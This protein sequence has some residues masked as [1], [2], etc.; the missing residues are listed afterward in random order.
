MKHF[1][2]VLTLV[3]I[4]NLGVFTGG[5]GVGNTVDRTKCITHV[6]GV[7]ACAKGVIAPSVTFLPLGDG[8]KLTKIFND[9]SLD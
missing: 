7:L 6:H 4:N 1:I 5:Q 2:P 9:V 8:M 3:A